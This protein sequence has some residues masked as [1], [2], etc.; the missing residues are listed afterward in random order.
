M[1]QRKLLAALTA[2]VLFT[3]NSAIPVSNF[4]TCAEKVNGAGLMASGNC[5]AMISVVDINTGKNVEGIEVTL[6]ENP[7]GTSLSYAPWN[8]SDEPVKEM[9]DLYAGPHA[10]YFKNVPEEYVL[11]EYK[12]FTFENTDEVKDIV[13]RAVPAKAIKKIAFPVWDF[14]D[15]EYDV[16]FNQYKYFDSRTDIGLSVYVYD[17]KGELFT[18][19]KSGNYCRHYLPDGK[20]RIKVVPGDSDYE[21]LNN[22]YY[23]A[24]DIGSVY[25]NIAFPDKDG[26]IDIE[27]I[28]GEMTRPCTILVRMKPEIAEERKEGCKANIAVFDYTTRA[29]VRGVKLRLSAGL[30]S[31][32][33]EIIEEWNTSD[34]PVKDIM[35]LD[36]FQWYTVE[37]VDA[38]ER[39]TINKES[40]FD[41]SRKGQRKDVYIPAVPVGEPNIDITVYDMTKVS[42]DPD[43]GECDGYRIMEPDEYT[44][45]INDG[46]NNFTVSDTENTKLHLPDGR[47]HAQVFFEK[48]RYSYVDDQS[49]RGRAVR[50]IFG[51]DCEIPEGYLYFDIKDGVTVGKPAFFYTKTDACSSCKV[52]L[53]VVDGVTGE[54]VDQKAQAYCEIYRVDEGME[55][56]QDILCGADRTCGLGRLYGEVPK[57]GEMTLE[58]VEPYVM[59]ILTVETDNMDYALPDPVIIK[60]IEDGETT[61]VTV[62]LMP[63]ESRKGDMNRDNNINAVDIIFM[64]R[65]LMDCFYG[66]MGEPENADI[67]ADG[68]V[69]IVDMIKLKTSVL[70]NEQ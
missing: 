24:E 32:D 64:Q 43:G 53:K 38:P 51:S 61:D 68:T 63:Y 22:G 58:Y 37:V 44:L 33:K 12:Y 4:G 17:D 65:Y 34:E 47:Y 6:M 21:I 5:T 41:F 45:S 7:L 62:K 15:A 31:I 36:D 8:T 16:T 9:T 14:T 42:Y 40:Y 60:F 52:N 30:T 27:V 1:K 59:N 69:N 67:N 11:P 13:I 29:V 10:I 56:N 23:Y 26:F 48:A 25:N 19:F 46:E 54:P 57:S 39:Y 18:D 3:A 28:N 50:R 20:Y 2:A 70:G 35:N 66:R 55:E 49:Y